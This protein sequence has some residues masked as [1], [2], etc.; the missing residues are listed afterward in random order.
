MT[1][2]DQAWN[3][4]KEYNP[5]WR[6]SAFKLPVLPND[7]KY[8]TNTLDRLND[9]SYEPSRMGSGAYFDVYPHPHDDRF[10]VKL[11]IVEGGEPAQTIFERQ[12]HPASWADE[13]YRRFPE[14]LEEFGFPVASELD[15]MGD[16]L[17]QPRLDT[18]AVDTGKGVKGR[19][20]K[21]IAD[22]ALEHM[23]SD[24]VSTNWGMDQT[25]NWRLLDP[26]MTR[27]NTDDYW[28]SRNSKGQSTGEQLQQTL[29]KFNVQI[30]ATALLEEIG[31][32]QDI[33]LHPSARTFLEEIE[34]HSDN[35]RLLTV[36]G[37]PVWREGY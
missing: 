11:P 26:D 15:M 19:P 14:I 35:P 29:D 12:G 28:P 27:I 18:S 22:L 3:L 31:N 5:K 8:E 33:N 9:D 23:F 20:T 21:G 25:G 1:A 6:E 16:Y 17:I 36:G 13:D 30:P 37:K 7:H 2:F 10:V 32:F 24:R 34:P 4:V